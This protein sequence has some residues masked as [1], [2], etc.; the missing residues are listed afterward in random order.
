MNK[1]AFISTPI[2]YAS[3]DPHIGHAY[4]TLLADVLTRY[5]K[6]LGY[7]VFFVTGTDEFG[8]KIETL[9]KKNNLSEQDFVNQNCK[10]FVNLFNKLG[11]DYNGFSRTTNPNHKQTVQKVFSQMIKN[12]DI[13]L[14]NWNGYY[15][16]NCEENY[17]KS[18]II[19]KDGEMLC[20]VG[21]KIIE[22][23]EESYFFKMSKYNEWINSFF[24]KNP[25]LI[26]PQH[27]I[28]ELKNNFLSDLTDLSVSRTTINWGIPVIENSQ[29]KIYVWVDALFNYLTILGYL[30]D[31][32]T[33]YKNFW[34]DD[35]CEK[36]H[37]MSKEI[38]RFHC[39]YWPIFLNS[40]GLNLPTKIYAHGWIVTKEGKM[41]K[42]LGNVIDPFQLIENY[43]RDAVRHFFIKEINPARDGVFS[44][45]I[46]IETINTDLANNIGNLVNRTI[47]MLKKYSNGIIPKYDGIVNSID[48]E[49]ENEIT[50]LIGN[51]ESYVNN[52]ELYLI[53]EKMISLVKI[54]NKYIEEYKP[55]EL[56]KNN[57]YNKLNSLLNHLCQIIRL[58]TIILSPVLIDGVNEI[59]NQMNF[60]NNICVFEK[61]WNFHLIDDIC[62]NDQKPIYQRFEISNNN[63]TE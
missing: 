48:D 37:I 55:W 31:N 14:D 38:T 39:I 29:H 49:I 60:S 27:R 32:D 47:G 63:E 24:D 15:C 4:T 10:K 1:K 18:Q 53:V 23:N 35:Q 3:G 44:N 2:Y 50:N 7:D 61:K 62:V 20:N 45:D 16:V 22:K 6:M 30:Q 46:F 13:Y 57:E 56:F 34:L 43:G 59:K 21:H 5:K 33:N 9:A 11:I 8:Q 54:A 17:T 58:I 51:L 25:N 19:E 40:L 12:G 26:Y 52:F 42:S 36:I 28:N 41:S